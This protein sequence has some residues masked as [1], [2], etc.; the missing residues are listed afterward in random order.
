MA[1]LELDFSLVTE[2]EPPAN[3]DE[4]ELERLAAFVIQSEGGEGGWEVTVALV[5]DDR[6]QALHRD[7]MGEDAPT[8][9][10]TFPLDEEGGLLR[11]GDVVISVDHANAG[12]WDLSPAE[13]I[14]FLIAHGVLHLLGWRDGTEKERARMLE[15]QRALLKRWEAGKGRIS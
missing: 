12:E 15:R 2:A 9:V 13:E 10:M 1:A 4:D 11:G 6:L 7:F 8:D 3:L 14:R 5:G